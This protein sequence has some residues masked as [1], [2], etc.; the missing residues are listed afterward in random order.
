MCG[1]C[2]LCDK[3][4]S[5]HASSGNST[6]SWMVNPSAASVAASNGGVVLYEGDGD[7]YVY[8]GNTNYIDSLLGRYQ[9]NQNNNVQT[10][11]GEVEQI[12]GSWQITADPAPGTAVTISYNINFQ[13]QNRYS[14][15][16]NL[17]SNQET[18]VREALDLWANVANINFVETN[19]T[20]DIGFYE[21]SLPVYQY[22]GGIPVSF[23]AG[24]AHTSTF[25]NGHIY[26]SDVYVTNHTLTYGVGENG[27]ATVIHEIGH[28]LGLK[29]PGDYNGNGSGDAPFLPNSQDNTDYSIMSYIDGT[30]TDNNRSPSSPMLYDIAAVQ[31][32]YGANTSYNSGDTTI[33]LTGANKAWAVWDGA[34]TDTLNA[35]GVSGNHVLDLRE[36]ESY[37]NTVGNE[38]I[39]MAFGANIENATGGSGT[40][41][42]TGNS[43]DNVLSGNGGAD[44]LAGGAGTDTLEG[45]AGSDTYQLA[46][47]DGT[48]IVSD[49]GS[50]DVI[51]VNGNTLSGTATN[52][53]SGVYTLVSN[54]VTHT[55]TTS[56][57][58]LVVRIQGNNSD[59]WTLQ[60]FSSG[61]FGIDLTTPGQVINGTNATSGVGWT[62]QYIYQD[63]T[64]F[65]FEDVDND[66]TLEF[67]GQYAAGD[68]YLHDPGVGWTAYL[69]AGGGDAFQIID[70]DN[71][72]QLELFTV[73]ASTGT[74]Y[75]RDPGEGW[76][77]HAYG[78]NAREF[79]YIDLDGD[80]T[81]EFV[82]RMNGNGMWTYDPDTAS[83]T[84]ETAWGTPDTFDMHDTDN[85]GTVEF[86]G[87]FGS[88][89]RMY[90]PDTASWTELDDYESTWTSFDVADA[91]N[92][93][94]IDFYGVNTNG[95][96]WKHD[97]YNDGRD[98]LTGGA[99]ND[100]INGGSGN[101]AIYAGTGND[102]FVFNSNFG[103]DI[104]HDF[105][106]WE[107]L[108]FSG[109]A[110]INN[111]ND[112][113][114]NITYDANHAYITLAGHGSITLAFAQP[115]DLDAAN[116][117][118]S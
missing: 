38:V 65:Q 32:L 55:L 59:S 118:F 78:D 69:N 68:M 114:T 56:G 49:D 53:G 115:G 11:S 27:Y 30:Y 79:Q 45:G 104:L 111:D 1:Y 82:A 8:N 23:V 61:D 29:H 89:L 34:G 20:A 76:S 77:T 7:A 117:E 95:V 90:D 81:L 99:G 64:N 102:R 19:G 103:H 63:A 101:D 116:F 10:W 57:N 113:L 91:N 83:W 6:S 36:G 86:Y 97:S 71:D 14:Q 72:G 22:S 105:R 60:N 100:T 112:I 73:W 109:I 87:L 94:A 66:G 92:D 42:I 21:A 44:T 51:T 47:G 43:L 28:A 96:V 25:S 40:D 35:A 54:N 15:T 52:S 24:V 4:S 26:Y 106:E 46:T 70:I 75:E 33:T 67:L 93:G 12:N 18:A 80:A 3:E 37:A 2:G 62:R 85:D 9:G 5:I 108:E 13:H 41:R 74:F 84:N 88:N 48:D 50:G 110:G 16:Q 31:Y 107:V 98:T 17:D 58:D 39:W